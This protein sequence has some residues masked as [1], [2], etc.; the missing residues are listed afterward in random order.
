[1]WILKVGVYDSFGEDA[2]R[3]RIDPAPKLDPSVEPLFTKKQG[4]Y[5]AFIYHYS[6][7]HGRAPAEADL[8]RYFQTTPPSVHQMIKT[9]ELSGFVERTPGQA[10]SIRLL[11]LPE[12]LPKLG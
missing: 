11:V 6:K 1:M 10:R 9:L 2:F 12:H 5:L 4:Q 3:V 7:I 8:Q